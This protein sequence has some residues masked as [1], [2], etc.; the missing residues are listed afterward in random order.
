MEDQNSQRQDPTL[1]EL[2]EQRICSLERRLEERIQGLEKSFQAHAVAHSR[3]HV[4]QE[5]GND[6]AKVEL[7][8]RLHDMNQMREQINVIQENSITRA[9]YDEKHAEIE[10]RIGNIENEQSSSKGKWSTTA[11]AVAIGAALAG[12]I[13]LILRWIGK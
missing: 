3:E 2:L 6:A 9:T 13:D 10:R 4:L 11:L 8:R 1:R 12:I 5:Q 7:N